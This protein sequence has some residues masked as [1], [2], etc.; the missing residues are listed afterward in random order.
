MVHKNCPRCRSAGPSLSGPGAVM[1]NVWWSATSISPCLSVLTFFSTHLASRA[2]KERAWD[3]SGKRDCCRVNERYEWKARV[4]ASHSGSYERR[5]RGRPDVEGNV[6]R[7][8]WISCAI[9]ITC[10]EIHSSEVLWRQLENVK[11]SGTLADICQEPRTWSRMAA[12]AE[13]VA[14]CSAH[15]EPLDSREHF[16][17]WLLL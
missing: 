4:M 15:R 8:G 10:H 1:T 11:G 9:S 6:C 3:F 12:V 7:E 16:R 17:V 5:S 14:H 2:T 13:V